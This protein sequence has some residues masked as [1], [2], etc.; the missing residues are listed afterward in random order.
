[1]TSETR[2]LEIAGRTSAPVESVEIR[3]PYSG[4]RVGRLHLAGPSELDAAAAESLR[5]F[6]AY[7]R[8]PAYRRAGILLAIAHGLAEDREGFAQTIVAEAAKP[9]R[10]ARVE[11]DRAAQTFTLAA[12]EAKRLV[13]EYLPLDLLPGSEGRSAIVRRVAAG[14]VLGITPFN[15]PLNLAA[16][17]VAP[18]L[19]CGAAIVL[20][21]APQTPFTAYRLA[22]LARTAGLPSGVFQVVPTTNQLAPK[23]IED[24]RFAVLSFTGSPGV[25]W[26]L[27]SRAGKKRVVLELGGNAAVI[28]HRDADLEHA[29]RRSVVGGYTYS[30]QVCISVQRVYV[31]GSLF[32]R[33]VERFLE[34]VKA[35]VLGDPADEATQVSALI[36]PSEVERIRGWVDEAVSGGARV[37]AGGRTVDTPGGRALEPVVLTGAPRDS[38]VV[39]E[40]VFGP[41]VVVERYEDIAHAFEAVNAGRFGLQAGLYTNELSV[42]QQAFERLE[43]GALLVNEVPTWR[44]DLMPYGGV[45]DSGF[46]REGVRYAIEEMTERRTLVLPGPPSES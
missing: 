25:G 21:P 46:G 19:A 27:K 1:M 41:L 43:V 33:F 28:V 15:F 34:S 9:L 7:R 35:L 24:P 23:L 12:E 14:P 5:A 29:V 42:V 44:S 10:D 18:A 17:K 38:K 30:G 11:V 22:D 45:K 31:H 40:E 20:K 13:G 26:G 4:H 8:E 37:L 6:E 2:E 39:A 36:R 16:H 32:D 3:N